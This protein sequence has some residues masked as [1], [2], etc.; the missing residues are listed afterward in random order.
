MTAQLDLL[1]VPSIRGAE[2]I[3]LAVASRGRGVTLAQL[4]TID[5]LARELDKDT[6]DEERIVWLAARLDIDPQDLERAR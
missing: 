3:A 1:H 4:G 5:A 2:G 6:P